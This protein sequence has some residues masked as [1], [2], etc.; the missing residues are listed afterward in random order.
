MEGLRSL[1]D[2]TI[3]IQGLDPAVA[4]QVAWQS[5]V[6]DVGAVQLTPA[7]LAEQRQFTFN[8]GGRQPN[9]YLVPS[10]Q[11]NQY[12]AIATATLRFDVVGPG[13]TYGKKALDLGF[14][15]YNFGG[16]PMIEDKDLRTDRIFCGDGD[17]LRKFEAIP[18]SMAEDGASEWTRVSGASGIADAVQG[19]M[20]WYIQ[21]GIMQRSAWSRYQNYTVPTTFQTQPPTL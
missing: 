19:L 2:D 21:P 11:I 4:A 7:L 14:M 12:V 3:A 5:L 18:L 15:V 13:A 20:R 8:R 16:L 10:A 17:A 1:I 9:M 6:R